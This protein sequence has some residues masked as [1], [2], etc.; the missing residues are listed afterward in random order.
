MKSVTR[1]TKKREVKKDE[2]LLLES[3]AMMSGEGA[4][5]KKANASNVR[6]HQ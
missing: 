4:P 1:K 5:S 6:S 2:K 3:Q